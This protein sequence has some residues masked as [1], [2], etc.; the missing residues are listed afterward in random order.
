MDEL[1][2]DLRAL[3]GLMA[4]SG[5]RGRVTSMTRT[6]DGWNLTISTAET[7]LPSLSVILRQADT[8]ACAV[9]VGM[10]RAGVNIVIGD[11]SETSPAQVRLRMLHQAGPVDVVCARITM[12]E[13]PRTA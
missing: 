5:G 4:V 3:T 11:V 8:S 10:L 12:S 7:A 13:S 1:R 9:V 6:S 2:G